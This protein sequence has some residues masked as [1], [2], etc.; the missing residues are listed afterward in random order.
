MLC[1]NSAG[2]LSNDSHVI[3]TAAIV[4]FDVFLTV[5]INQ[6]LICYYVPPLFKTILT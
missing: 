1:N 4:H 6:Y 5:E 3:A 2:Q